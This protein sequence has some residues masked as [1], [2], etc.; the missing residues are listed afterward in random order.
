[1]LELI[2]LAV[3]LTVSCVCIKSSIFQFKLYVLNE[4]LSL[5]SAQV[6]LQIRRVKINSWDRSDFYFKMAA[7]PG[8][9]LCDI[10]L[11]CVYLMSKLKFKF[12]P[13]RIFVQNGDRSGCENL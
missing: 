12:E 6:C 8:T 11:Q 3:L 13:N 9:S 10:I 5:R 7:V 1:M 4:Q 2:I